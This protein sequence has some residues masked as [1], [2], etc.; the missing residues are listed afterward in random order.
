MED[1]KDGFV[2]FENV[3]V[4]EVDKKN[5]FDGMTCPSSIYLRVI[6]KK[7]VKIGNA[8]EKTLFSTLKGF[9]NPESRVYV[10]KDEYPALVD[11]LASFTEQVVSRKEVPATVRANFLSTVVSDALTSFEDIG[12]AEYHKLNRVAKMI[13]DFFDANDSF[14][15]VT[16]ILETMPGEESQH[17]VAVSLISLMI[18]E[19]MGITQ[20]TVLEKVSFSA[21]VHDIG[22]KMIPDSIKSKP[23]HEWTLEENKIYETHPFVGVE[24]LRDL[25]GVT[26]D[27]LLMIIE[28]HENANGSGFPK[29]IRDVKTSPLGKILILADFFAD[30]LY[31][32]STNARLHSADSGIEYIEQVLG[33]PFNKT[34]FRALKNIVNKNYMKGKG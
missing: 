9:S 14:A 10:T 21:M 26:N 20:K 30:L 24:M 33:Q 8:G 34:A 1:K 17:A 16:K 7:Y 31:G 15:E 18:C 12:V 29:R 23:R 32:R 27:M 3:E 11:F 19:E 22:L 13:V 2:E 4:V 25:K 6:N 28:H 5:L